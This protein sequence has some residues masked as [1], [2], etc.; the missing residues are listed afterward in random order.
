MIEPDGATI[1]L[2][3]AA[4]RRRLEAILASLGRAAVAVSGGVDSMLLA[5]LCHAT[6]GD[7]VAMYHATSPAVPPEA[8]DRARRHA[9]RHGW[10]LNVI[11]AGEFAD[12]RY[13][14][15]PVNRCFFCKIN[16]YGTIA[17]ATDAPILSGANLD[18]LGDFRPGLAAAARHGVRHPLVEAGI[19]KATVRRLA[20]TAGLDEL[21][22]LPASP[23]LS[24]RLTT[25]IPVSAD[26]LNLVLEGERFVKARVADARVI[27]CRV[28]PGGVEIH[29]DDS[30]LDR[31]GP[32]ER[33]SIAAGIGALCRRY[34]VA[35]SIRFAPYARGSA[36]VGEG[37]S[38][39]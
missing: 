14:A 24:S 15:N 31:L 2:P 36:F 17:G 39:G 23:C 33:G 30:T 6:L 5:H 28:V 21:A 7:R 13:L 27:R 18:D 8:T 9:L 29:L 3:D 22:E 37:K 19:D 38:A 35:G 11:E 4:A 25:G 10:A 32:R 34:G 20:A 26:R 16:L 1:G 12:S